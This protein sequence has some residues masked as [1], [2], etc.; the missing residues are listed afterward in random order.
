[1]PGVAETLD[2]AKALAALHAD[3]LDDGGVDRDARLRA[4]GR[5]RHQAVPRRGR[6]D[7]PH[8]RRS[9]SRASGAMA[10]QLGAAV[11]R[12]A[13]RLR[14]RR[15]PVSRDQVPDAGALAR[16]PRHLRSHELYL[17][18][19]TLFVGRAPRKIPAFDR[20]F[21]SSGAP[22]AR[23]RKHG[24]A[25]ASAARRTPT[26]R[27]RGWRAAARDAGAGGVGRGRG[28]RGRGNRWA[29]RESDQESLAGRTSPTFRATSSTRCRGSRS[30]SR[31]GSRVASA[32][33]G[34]PCG[35]AARVDLRR[36][37]RANLTRG[38]PHRP[39]LRGRASARR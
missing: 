25:L 36:T 26:T 34:V 28:G 18:C 7:R 13:A 39:A 37:L 30:R 21:E 31:V 1:M 8:A 6:E 20:C 33:A 10:R 16:S 4:E 32:G 22:A 9:K 2:W 24:R 29:C 19:R 5:R 11:T 12:F 35:A 15:L 38:G 3:H 23:P 27:A 14:T 17:G